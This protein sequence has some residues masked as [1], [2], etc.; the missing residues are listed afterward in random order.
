MW[1]DDDVYLLTVPGWGGSGPQHWQ[2]RW[3][4]LYPLALR[5]EQGDWLYPERDAW[6]AAVGEAV[7]SCD[8]RVVIAAHSLGCHA[9]VEW[10]TRAS[11]REQRR[12]KGLLL[13]APPALPIDPGAARASGELP[14]DA[15]LP[16]FAGFEAASERRIA[17]PALLVASHDD[18]F[19]PWVTSQELAARWGAELVDAGNAGHMGS[20]SPLGGWEAGQRLLQRLMLA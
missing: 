9:A 3:E 13:V 16:A 7:A 18:P 8:G 20:A 15:P 19:C 14:A 2:T 4:R 11:L 5:V 12:V 6:M 10:F 17:A 1:D